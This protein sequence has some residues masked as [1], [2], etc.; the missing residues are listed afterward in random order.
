MKDYVITNLG[1]GMLSFLAG[2]VGSVIMNPNIATGNIDDEL[3]P[4]TVAGFASLTIMGAR[5]A[6]KGLSKL[7]E[8]SREDNI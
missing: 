2:Y 6:K 7:I 5:A 8:N 3:R 1:Y 4:Y